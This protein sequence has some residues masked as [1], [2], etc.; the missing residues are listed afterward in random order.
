MNQQIKSVTWY[1]RIGKRTQHGITHKLD[2]SP[3]SKDA[4]YKKDINPCLKKYQPRLRSTWHNECIV[5][6]LA[7][8]KPR[9]LFVDAILKKYPCKHNSLGRVRGQNFNIRHS[10]TKKAV[11]FFFYWCLLKAKFIFLLKFSNQWLFG[12]FVVIYAFTPNRR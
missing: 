1:I 8:I 2:H 5:K 7:I 6:K 9:W 11:V 4:W 3:H 12:I 10:E